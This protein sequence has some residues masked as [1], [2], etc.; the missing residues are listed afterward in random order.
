VKSFAAVVVAAALASAP[1][2]AQPPA[3]SSATE[4]TT[5]RRFAAIRANP[6]RLRAF[7]REMP[8]G[9]DLHNHLSGAVYAERYLAWAAEDGQCL[10]VATMTIVEGPCDAKAGLPSARDVLQN[11]T[12]YDQAID[13]MSMRHWD[14]GLNGHDHFFASFA[15]FGPASDK[16]GDMLAEVAANAAAEH[17][18][19]LELM[20]TPDGSAAAI[21][22]TVAPDTDFGRWRDRLIAAGLVD[23]A[24]T[25]SRAMIDKAETRQREILRC[26]TPQADP[27]CAVTIRYIAQVGRTRPLEVVFAQM[28]AWF[29]LVGAD[30][31]FV[32]LNLVQPEDDP[33]AVGNFA[34]H[35]SM[36]DFLHRQYPNVA[37]ALHAG[38]LVNGLVPPDALR[39][40]VRQSIRKGHARRIGHA[41][42]AVLEDDP[43]GLLRE[44]AENKIVVEVAMTSADQ[45]LGVHGSRHPL[46][47][48][49]EH[50]VPVTIATDDMGV[51]RSSHTDEFM[52]AVTDHDLDY[53]TVKRMVRNSIE[54]SFADEKTKARLKSGLEQAFAA[55]ERAPH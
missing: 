55:F 32:A 17:V 2:S 8:K 46:R 52:K 38:E 30:P 41:T 48:L 37:I 43:F 6:I 3:G 23:R 51:S 40:H 21:G 14:S 20:L 24:V 10:A 34:E 39:S 50:D 36:L 31:R 44:M 12:L 22:R 29:A 9:G 54:F 49:L 13:A 33:A 4:A 27:G 16:T 35:M 42:A 1:G 15:K 7:L 47:T 25:G 11:L 18:S 26:G 28:V 45:I 5:A 53:A 19:Y